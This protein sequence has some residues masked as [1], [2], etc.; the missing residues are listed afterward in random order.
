[1]KN[2]ATFQL[3]TPKS[4]R[5]TP[6]GSQFMVKISVHCMSGWTVPD[7]V[8]AAQ[9]VC[10]PANTI[11]SSTNSVCPAT[12]AVPGGRVRPGRRG[13]HSPLG[14]GQEEEEETDYHA[15]A[16]HQVNTFMSRA[17]DDGRCWQVDAEPRPQQHGSL[18]LRPSCHPRT[19]QPTEPR[20]LS[21]AVL[22]VSQ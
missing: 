5:P 9:S 8:C 15:R 21:P 22:P 12:V 1:M 7:S 11:C 20:Q 13:L 16:G 14:S 17:V 19:R 2:D 3:S 10:S 18:S 4:A 6:F